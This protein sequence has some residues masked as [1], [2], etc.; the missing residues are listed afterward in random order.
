[1]LRKISIAVLSAAAV[2]A[3]AGAFASDSAFPFSVNES[4][5]VI[6]DHAAAPSQPAGR[7]NDAAPVREIRGG[8]AAL[9]SP[10][11]PS[12]VSESAPWLTGTTR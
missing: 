6:A 11:F 8:N 5:P 1:M 2:F 10:S 3:S 7:S 4:G 9:V 12:S